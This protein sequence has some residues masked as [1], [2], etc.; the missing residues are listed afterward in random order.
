[1][2]SLEFLEAIDMVQIALDLGNPGLYSDITSNLLPG[3]EKFH[4]LSYW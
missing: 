2:R 4:N 1:M 3:I